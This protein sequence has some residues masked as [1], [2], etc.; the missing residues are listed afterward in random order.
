SNCVQTVTK[1]DGRQGPK[2]I[3]SGR[4]YFQWS[5]VLQYPVLKG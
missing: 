4:D 1:E 5:V 3:L 2:K